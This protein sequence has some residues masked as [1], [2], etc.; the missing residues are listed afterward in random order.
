M[1]QKLAA[2]CI[3]PSQA[4]LVANPRTRA[5]DTEE[6][7]ELCEQC[8]QPVNLSAACRGIDQEAIKQEGEHK[9]LKPNQCDSHSSIA[10]RPQL[11]A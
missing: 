9:Q 3:L 10:G 1:V 7:V 6:A 4:K 5:R 2:A 11:S 8:A